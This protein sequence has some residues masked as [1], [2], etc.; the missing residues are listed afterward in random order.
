MSW[1][2]ALS[3]PWWNRSTAGGQEVDNVRFGSGCL[4]LYSCAH[5]SHGGVVGLVGVQLVL[6]QL[7][8]GGV[9]LV[10]TDAPGDRQTDGQTDGRSGRRR[11]LVKPMATRAAKNEKRREIESVVKAREER[12]V[13]IGAAV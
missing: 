7:G 13:T 1:E 10:L 8:Q 9:V 6:N 12:F 5:L 2:R 3:G 11:L 4:D